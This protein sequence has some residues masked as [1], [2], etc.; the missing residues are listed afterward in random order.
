LD[1][2]IRFREEPRTLGASREDASFDS[3]DGFCENAKL[4]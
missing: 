3:F 1:S 4:R 2:F